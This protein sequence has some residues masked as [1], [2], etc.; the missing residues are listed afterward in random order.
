MGFSYAFLVFFLDALKGFIPVTIALNLTG[1]STII[2]L[3][4][5]VLTIVGHIYSIFVKFKGGRGVAPSI[6]VLM[7]LSPDVCIISITV[8]LVIIL[9]TRIVSISSIATSI[10]VPCLLFIFSYPKEYIILF[11]IIS[12]LLIIKHSSNIKR[13]LKGTENRV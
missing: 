2:P 5:G 7:A 6:G 11:G 12:V 4:V 9:T 10:L 1:H 8:G 3:G 13:L